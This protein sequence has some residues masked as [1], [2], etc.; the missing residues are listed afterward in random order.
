VY[1]TFVMKSGLLATKWA[2][3]FEKGDKRKSVYLTF[4]TARRR[5]EA[6]KQR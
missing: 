6:T 3:V 5:S 4:V 2:F 1:F